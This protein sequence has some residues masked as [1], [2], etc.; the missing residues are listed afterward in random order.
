MILVLNGPLGVGKTATAWQLLALLHEAALVDIDHVVAVRPFDWRLAAHRSYAYS[1]AALL[2][3]HHIRHGYQHVVVTW[4]FET[5]AELMA[6]RKQFVGL[7]EVFVCRLTC[8]PDTLAGRV[9]ARANGNVESEVTRALELQAL[10][11]AAAATGDLGVPV[12]AE[13]G[14]AYQVAQGVL[15]HVPG[16]LPERAERPV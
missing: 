14:T 12:S 15:A 3:G 16:Y 9:R 8:S 1:S 4:V 6:L 2:A 10:L 5:P 13:E 11:E 7:G